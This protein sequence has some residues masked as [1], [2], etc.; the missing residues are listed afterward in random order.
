MGRG[1][2]SSIA[3]RLRI[4]LLRAIAISKAPK[5]TM[6]YLVSRDEIVGILVS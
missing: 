1:S 4:M 6:V 3:V 5:Q 2:T